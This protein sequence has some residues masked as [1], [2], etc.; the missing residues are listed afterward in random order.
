MLNCWKFIDG[1]HCLVREQWL[2]WKVEGWGM[3]VLKEKLKLIK[4]KLKEWHKSHTQNLDGKINSAKEELNNIESKDELEGLSMEEIDNKRKVVVELHKLTNLNCSI[5]CQ[6]SR[7]EWLSEGDTN[8]KY[9]HGCINK[10]RKLNEIMSLEVNG[11]ILKEAEEI[12]EEVGAHFQKI[13][14]NRGL[15]PIHVNIEFKK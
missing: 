8:S 12:K 13:F 6:R 5:M 14:E 11:G 9:F 2:N 1:Y 4:R 10:R 3:F 7:I 15:R